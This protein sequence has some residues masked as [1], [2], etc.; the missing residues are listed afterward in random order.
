MPF[1]DPFGFDAS[2]ILSLRI[3]VAENHLAIGLELLQ[4]L[5]RRE[6]VALA[7]ADWNRQHLAD[8]RR[9]RER[10][11]VLLDAHMHVLAAIFQA[12]VAQHRAG[13]QAGLEQNLEAV[14]DAEHRP[15]PLGKRPHRAHHGREPGHR[16]GAQ[17]VAVGET[18][19]QDHDVGAF[20]VGVLVPQILGILAEHVPGRVKRVLVAVAAGKHDD[21]EFHDQ[22]TSMR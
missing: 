13:Q 10:R 14:A 3:D 6:V 7:V 15:A 2:S 11:V 12:F 4:H 5:G 18:A 8:R 21:A 22:S 20:Q 16:A 9:G 1:T 17:V 19:R